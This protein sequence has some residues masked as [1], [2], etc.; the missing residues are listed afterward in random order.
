MYKQVVISTEKYF[1]KLFIVVSRKLRCRYSFS[2][3]RTRILKTVSHIQ[4][5]EGLRVAKFRAVSEWFSI[6]TVCV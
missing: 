2:I 5:G 4:M 3:F 6:A 1:K